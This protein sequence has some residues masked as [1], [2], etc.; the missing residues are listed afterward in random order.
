MNEDTAEVES[1]EKPAIEPTEK[2]QAIADGPK[3]RGRKPLPRDANGN[4][5]RDSNVPASASPVRHAKPVVQAVTDE[6]AGK[7]IQGA[8]MLASVGLGPH[9]RLFPQ[10][11][12]DMGACFG[13]LFRKYPDKIGDTLSLLMIA[14]TVVGVMMPR[15]M[16]SKLKAE[17]KIEK[18]EERSTVLTM[19]SFMEAE[20]QLNMA[21]AVKE[22]TEY[23]K[24][25]VAGSVQAVAME[26]EKASAT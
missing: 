26:H 13:P 18:G 7:A 21:E 4:I 17:G 24:A 1:I 6:E 12:Q 8:F 10:E 23:L 2:A 14:P 19:I 3:K 16:V 5:V 25:K 22:S 15:I 11:Q 20:K 9:F